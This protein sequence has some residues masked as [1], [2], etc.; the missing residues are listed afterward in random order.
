MATDEVAGVDEVDG[1]L[2]MEGRKVFATVIVM[3]FHDLLSL[4]HH[5]FDP[6]FFLLF[7]SVLL[8]FL[9]IRRVCVV[10]SVLGR[11]L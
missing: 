2:I 10:Y 6:C 4:L 5:P 3:I 9:G 1:G 11:F 7:A 8:S